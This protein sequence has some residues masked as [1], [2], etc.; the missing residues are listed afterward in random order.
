MQF[1]KD[2]I[3]KDDF[4]LILLSNPLK[5]VIS[6]KLMEIGHDNFAVLTDELCHRQLKQE[7]Q[8]CY[9]YDIDGFQLELG[10]GH[11]LPEVQKR[12][13]M[14]DA[15]IPYLGALT[16]KIMSPN[17]GWIVD[18]GANVGDTTAAMLRHT[19][20]SVL[21][22]E[23]TDHFF[24][25]LQRNVAAFGSPFSERVRLTKAFVSLNTGDKFVSKVER[26]T[27]VNVITSGH[28]EADAYTLPDLLMHESIELSQVVL[29]KTDTDGYDADCMLSI[30]SEL[31]K[32][33]P[34][35][36]WE[37]QLDNMAQYRK[38]VELAHCLEND[39]YNDFFVF[40]NFGNFLTHTNA[41]GL[42][43]IDNYL[44]RIQQNHSARTF[45]YV[46]VLG[47][48][49]LHVQLCSQIVYEYLN[50]WK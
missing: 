37:N 23:P 44:L 8:D 30:D 48:K 5:E 17:G 2:K 6:V 49:P 1:N 9:I 14:Y 33:Q 31:K 13:P 47:C 34:L 39:G 7:L 10:K 15:F 32:A 36:Y 22:V 12:F 3:S 21:C 43:D 20:A 35:L 11:T 4:V 28:S 38:Y 25:L 46:D 40:D 19:Q 18:V 29:I 16:D 45:Y 27:A 50:T 24:S 42:I 41:D 26:G